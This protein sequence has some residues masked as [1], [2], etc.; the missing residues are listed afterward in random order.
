MASNNFLPACLAWDFTMPNESVLPIEK[1]AGSQNSSWT[2]SI[3]S[4]LKQLRLSY[5][6]CIKCFLPSYVSFAYFCI[7]LLD[8]N[9]VL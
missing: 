9:N 8:I 3:S 4:N 7:S 5:C 2:I 6:I 1:K